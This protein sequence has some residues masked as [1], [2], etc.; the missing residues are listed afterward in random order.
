MSDIRG[1]A[2]ITP[3]R[4]TADGQFLS[5][6]LTRDGA[7]VEAP[8]ALARAIEGLVYHANIGGAN[9]PV[10]FAKTTYDADQPQLVIDVPSDKAIIPLGIKVALQDSAGTDNIVRVA[11]STV[12][13]GAGTSTTVTPTN[14]NVGNS[15]TSSCS[16]YSLY[17]GNG[18]DPAT[19]TLTWLDTWVYAFADTQG[20]AHMLHQVDF[21]NN[22]GPVVIQGTGSL[23]VYIVG[24]ST[25]SAG[26]ASVTWVEVPVTMV[27]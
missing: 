23:V 9:T 13:V 4:L 24:T 1:V 26:Y 14:L 21:L 3:T 17:T 16:A 7:I 11:A 5:P 10:S 2:S 6:Q 25:A 22:G 12:N 19:G 8:Y 18:T 20:A 27:S 15:N